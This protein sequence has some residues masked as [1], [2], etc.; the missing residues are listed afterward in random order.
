MRDFLIG[1]VAVIGVFLA[2][3][4]AFPVLLIAAYCVAVPVLAAVIVAADFFGKWLVLGLA[5][6][7]S[8]LLLCVLK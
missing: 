4:V 5:F 8:V 2:L 1:V 6:V 7:A 3:L